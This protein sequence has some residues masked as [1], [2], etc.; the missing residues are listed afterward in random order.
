MTEKAKISLLYFATLA[1]IVML[2]GSLFLAPYSKC[3]SPAISGFLYALFSPT[4][5]QMP[6]RCFF[7]YGYP[8]TVC[9]RCLGI[10]CGFLLGTLVLP[11][12]NGLSNTNVP[13][14]K[15]F[16]LLSLPIVSD[17]AGNFL[18]IWSS[19]N[20]IRL[21]TGILWGIALPFYF[22]AGLVDLLLR[23]KEKSIPPKKRSEQ[24]RIPG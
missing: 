17:A 14:A 1:G 22:L 4:C 9:A 21:L 18:G 23:K 24:S 19:P 2:I 12:F 10:Y 3:R 13:K 16:I 8:L 5:H 11:F 6:S 15:T 7:V 20:W